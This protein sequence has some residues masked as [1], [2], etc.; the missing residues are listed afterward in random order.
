MSRP[1]KK[2]KKILVTGG[3]GFIGSF[4]VDK[5]IEKNYKVKILDNLEEQVHRGKKPSYLNKKAEFIVGDV[6][7]YQTFKKALNDIDAVFHLAAAVGVAQSNYEIK[8]Y[9]D[10]NIGGTAN[11]LDI[12]VNEKHKVKKL[13]TASSMT[14]FGEGN[15]KCTKCGVVRPLLR[16]GGQLKKHDWNIYCPNCKRKVEP[17]P[18]EDDAKEFP[19]SIY[20][21]T[22]KAQQDMALLHASLYNFPTVILRGFNVYGPRQSLSNPYTGVSAIFISR[23]KNNKEAV[24]YEDGLQSRDFVS[25]HDVTRA[26]VL[27]LEKDDANGKVVNIA[28]G[29]PTSIKKI[30]EILARR[31]NKKSLVKVSGEYR[32]NDIRHCFADISNAK[33]LLGWTP[34]ISLEE[35]FKEL[36]EWGENQKAVDKFT[37]A[38]KELRKKRIL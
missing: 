26:F 19:N 17:I 21:I 4:L 27:A 13:I 38:E 16:K 24:C 9:I 30:A 22:K 5:L 12:L 28:S 29:K 3:A 36:V 15:Y 34:K 32:K 33:K 23:L 18:T 2:F 11:L 37:S 20:A 1:S 14:G 10:V 31:L 25:V 7:N 35:G 8:R 6:R